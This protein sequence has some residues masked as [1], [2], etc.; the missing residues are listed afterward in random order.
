MPMISRHLLRYN[1]VMS[2]A[3][4]SESASFGHDFLCWVHSRSALAHIL[5]GSR[6]WAGGPR[7]SGSHGGFQIVV[8]LRLG[9][10]DHAPPSMFAIGRER[11]SIPLAVG[12]ALC[13]APGSKPS[14]LRFKL[15][16][17]TRRDS[18]R[19]RRQW[20]YT[21]LRQRCAGP[22]LTNGAAARVSG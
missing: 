17:P 9:R 21:P 20:R 19:R 3:F 8:E 14:L 5:E 12:S 11:H 22:H 7:P 2:T 4:H 18:M 10:T 15:R 13:L 16:I 1:R 6:T